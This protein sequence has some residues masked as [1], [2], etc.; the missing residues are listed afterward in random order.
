M[1][2]LFFATTAKCEKTEQPYSLTQKSRTKNNDELRKYSDLR[3][4][5]I[6]TIVPLQSLQSEPR[7]PGRVLERRDQ[8]FGKRQGTALRPDCVT[9]ARK[10]ISTENR[11]KL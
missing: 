7:E 4:F 2:I 5:R 11:A 6:V 8:P 3:R 10:Y 9:F 1:T